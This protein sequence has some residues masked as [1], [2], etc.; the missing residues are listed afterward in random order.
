MFENLKKQF[1]KKAKILLSD[2]FKE[3]AIK[4]VSENKESI[5]PAVISF[6]IVILGFIVGGKSSSKPAETSSVNTP[7]VINNYIYSDKSD[8]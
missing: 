5:V 3:T 1:T 7:I 6:G 2:S 4:T 8:K